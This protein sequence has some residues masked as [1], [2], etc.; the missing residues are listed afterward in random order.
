MVQ[1]RCIQ[2]GANQTA[3]YSSLMMKFSTLQFALHHL[4]NSKYKSLQFLIDAAA[5]NLY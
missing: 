2:G 1:L 5:T 3:T 4:C